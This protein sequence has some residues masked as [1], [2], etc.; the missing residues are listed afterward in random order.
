MTVAHT[1]TAPRP[2]P[3]AALSHPAT[4]GRAVLWAVVAVNVAIV[5]TLYFTS[6]PAAKNTLIAIAKFFGLNA[7]LLLILQIVL[8]A[9]VPWLDRR[10]GMDRLTAWHRWVGFG[11]FWAVVLHPTFILVGYARFDKLPIATE[12][13]NFAGV[14]GTLMGMIAA[15]T[16]IV[17]VALSVRF[18]R[19]RLGYETWHAVHVV[20]YAAI[21]LAIIH[22]MYEPTSFKTSSAATVYWWLM[23]GLAIGALLVG[24]VVVPL[25][26]NARHRLRVVAVVPESDTVTSVYMQGRHLDRLDARPGQ[27]FIWRFLSRDL[28]WQANP[29][30]LSA[31]PDGRTLRLTAKA[32][33]R[34]SAALRHLKV[35]TRVYVEGPY[36]AFT[37]YHRSKEAT[38]LV[39]GG[40]GVTPIRALLEELPG[41]VTV[42]YRVRSASDAVLLRELDDLAR[43]RGARL[44]VLAGRTGPGNNPFEPANLLALV[45]DIRDRDVFVCGPSAM[46]T[47]VL[48]A[49]RALGLPR[50]QV[51]AE[52]FSLAGT[53]V[54]PG[55]AVS[56][57]AASPSG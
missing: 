6:D 36:G 24:R 48:R 17:V 9:R 33:G 39:A 51:H 13:T 28:W 16:I 15:G 31:A 1:D 8:I 52:R 3:S 43:A 2:T 53:S 50:Q 23:W 56:A 41:P 5:E 38:L 27:F 32:V 30:S 54:G 45:P 42:L 12:F 46:T 34:T 19:R 20:L 55:P 44:H 18:A 37:S 21:T 7:A 22:Q 14:F 11:I 35:G 29:F 4:A 10:I 40:V 26:V 47:A 57:S 49:L 25:L